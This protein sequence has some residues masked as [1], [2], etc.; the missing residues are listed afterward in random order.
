MFNC[1]LGGY[2]GV[3]PAGPDNPRCPLPPGTE[4]AFGPPRF[5]KKK[6]KKE[7]RKKEERKKEERKKKKEKKAEEVGASAGRP[8]GPTVARREERSDEACDTSRAA[9]L[10]GPEGTNSATQKKNKLCDILRWRASRFYC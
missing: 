7:E 3:G 9:S 10:V 8:E 1:F 5:K 2:A 4:G 6:E